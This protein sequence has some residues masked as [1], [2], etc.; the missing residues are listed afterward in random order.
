M[1]EED[2]IIDK[3]MEK[4]NDARERKRY[5]ATVEKEGVVNLLL[6]NTRNPP[7]VPAAPPQRARPGYPRHHV[8]LI[9]E[10]SDLEGVVPYEAERRLV[11]VYGDHVHQTNGCHMDG[12][13]EENYVWQMRWSL[14]L[15]QPGSRYRATQGAMGRRFVEYLTAELQGA[16]D[17]RWNTERP[18]VFMGVIL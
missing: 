14:L 15:S 1:E 9:E 7:G 8:V 16:R 10:V 13:I 5:S 4:C 11:Q 2:Q 17:Q 3:N 18:M 6:E 12:G